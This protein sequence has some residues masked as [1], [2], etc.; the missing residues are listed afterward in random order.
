MK[1]TDIAMIILIAAISVAVAYFIA[2]NIPFLKPPEEGVKVQTMTE[3]SAEVK[4][5]SK[6]IFNE[7]A[8]NPTVK[9]VVGSGGAD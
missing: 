9:V 2:I 7:D 6:D 4:Q 5:P 1:K 8:V 3:I